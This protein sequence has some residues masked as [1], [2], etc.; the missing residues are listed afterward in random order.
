MAVKRPCSSACPCA[1]L[2]C[3]PSS[4]LPFGLPDLYFLFAHL[5]ARFSLRL[6]GRLS[7]DSPR[8]RRCSQAMVFGVAMNSKKNTLV[9]LLIAANFTEIKGVWSGRK[10]GGAAAGRAGGGATALQMAPLLRLRDLSLAPCTFRCVNGVP[11]LECGSRTTRRRK[12]GHMPLPS[13]SRA[14]HAGTVLK[15]FD[16]SKLFSLACQDVVERFHLLLIL[17]FVIVEEMGNRWGLG[18]GQGCL[19]T[20]G[21]LSLRDC[22]WEH[23]C[24][25][26]QLG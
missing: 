25:R 19:G 3:V 12:A 10:G 15:R 26:M 2:G 6:G 5:L 24:A 7:H 16:T 13:P 1:L 17:A 9:A 18:Q 23:A 20:L 21:M 22:I 8:P 14:R 4:T 11:A